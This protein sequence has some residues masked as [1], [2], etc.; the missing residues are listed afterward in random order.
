MDTRWSTSV[1]NRVAIEIGLAVLTALA[2]AVI[3][4][5]AIPEPAEVETAVMPVM[6]SNP[7][8]NGETP[9]VWQQ[10]EDD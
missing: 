3:L 8:A 2:V 6:V 9:I 1:S 4:V 5:P 7:N 10:C